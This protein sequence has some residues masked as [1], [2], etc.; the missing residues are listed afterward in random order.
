MKKLIFLLIISILYH[1]TVLCQTNARITD[2]DYRL[3]N[4]N[5]VINYYISGY[6]PNEIFTIGGLKFRVTETNQE[7]IPR[8]ITGDIGENIKGEGIKTIIWD[9]V[10]DQLEV[11]GVL[12]A[13]IDIIKSE[14]IKPLGGPGYAWLSVFVP[15]LG[16]YFVVKN[17]A[18]PILTTIS[19]IGL[20]T[21]GYLEKKK[22]DEYYADYNDSKANGTQ[23]Q[24][25]YDKANSAHKKSYITIRAA[26]TIWAFD[27]LWVTAKGS[28]NKKAA[29]S[30]KLSSSGNRIKLNYANNELQLGYEIVF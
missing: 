27:I 6:L 26:I 28:K 13:S 5:I 18:R 17:K 3:E 21:Y 24:S 29:Q 20:L 30:R 2:I 15:S 22:A 1:K 12:K 19:T 8:T 10:A 7:I 4:N 14:I 23:L 9:I 11:S 25:L 16:G